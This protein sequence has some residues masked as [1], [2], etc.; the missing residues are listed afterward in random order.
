MQNNKKRNNR[1]KT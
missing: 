1:K